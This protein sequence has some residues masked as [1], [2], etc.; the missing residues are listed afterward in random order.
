MR[1]APA[2]AAYMLYKPKYSVI[3]NNLLTLLLV[4]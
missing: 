1:S 3:V 4:I 2:T